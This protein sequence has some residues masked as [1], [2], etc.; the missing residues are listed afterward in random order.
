M[1]AIILI[2]IIG[3]FAWWSFSQ[4]SKPR[5]KSELEKQ[6]ELDAWSEDTYRRYMEKDAELSADWSKSIT[7]SARS[8]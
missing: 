5:E 3:S 1:E 7:P 8:K 6:K 4:S 2:L